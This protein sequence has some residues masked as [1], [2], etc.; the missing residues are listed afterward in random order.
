M[1]QA[2]ITSGDKIVLVNMETGAGINY[3]EQPAGDMWDNLHPYAMGYSKMAAEWKDALVS[4]LPECKPPM[5]RNDEFT[6]V[7]DS[8]TTF[9]MVLNNDQGGRIS[10]V[11]SGSAGGSLM[12]T[13]NQQEIRYTPAPNYSG[14]E[15]FPYTLDNGAYER[16]ATVTVAVTPVNDPLMP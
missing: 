7:E 16:H 8:S 3:N 14:I 5:A 13:A 11:G 4:F 2:R 10:G 9:L 15:V 1:A 12:I 6:V